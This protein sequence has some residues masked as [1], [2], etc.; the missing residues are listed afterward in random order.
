MNVLL[1]CTEKL[2]VPNIRGGAIQTYIGGVT[3]QISQYHR[4]TIVGRDDPELPADEV[5]HGVRYVRI[6]SGGVFETYADGVV[7]FLSASGEHY[8]VIHIFNRPRMVLPV[9]SVAPSSRIVLSMHN[10]MFNPAKIRPE[11]AQAVIAHTERI[12]TISNYIGSEIARYFP[13]V[14]PKLRTIY[15]GVDLDRFAPWLE[16]QSAMSIRQSLRAQHQLDS[17][18]VILFVGRLSRNKGP[19]VLVRAMSHVKHSNAVLVVVG[20]AWYS[21]NRVSD[22]IGYVRAIAE[23]SPLPVITTGYIDAQEVH[24]WFSAADVFVCTSIWN[25]PLARVHYEAMAAGLPF[26]T[27]ARGGNPE[28]IMNNNG[29]LVEDPDNP[30]DY[31]EKLNHLLSNMDE[32]RQMGLRGRRLA[33]Q[34]FH[35]DRVAQD[36]L[37]VWG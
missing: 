27:T 28:I 22:Y 24:R 12:V 7:Q 8:D 20:G 18:K 29:L 37:S 25:E 32:C 4:I 33:E 21:D 26:M 34:R 11:E 1:I 2:P 6:P 14:E 35:W 30:L 16:S 13:D 17:K 10:D 19:H 23:R 36:I 31:A 15:S 5:V 3:R 9:R